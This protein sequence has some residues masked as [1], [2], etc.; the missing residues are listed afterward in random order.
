[1]TKMT[2]YEPPHEVIL[3][4]SRHNFLRAFLLLCT[5]HC[6]RTDCIIHKDYELLGFRNH[7]PALSIGLDAYV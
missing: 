6:Y 7:V 4:P 1:M 2:N 3:D 5:C